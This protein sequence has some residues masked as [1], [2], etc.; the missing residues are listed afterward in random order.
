MKDLKKNLVYGNLTKEAQVFLNKSNVF[1]SF[2]EEFA[3]TPYNDFFNTT[4]EITQIIKV[5]R[6]AERNPKWNDIKKFNELCDGDLTKTLRVSLKKLQIPFDDNYIEYLSQLS[7][8]LGGLIMQLKNHYQRPRPY[9]IAY[10]SN[11]PLHPYETI[12]GNTPAYP[13]GHATQGRFLTKVIASHYPN[14]RIELSKL[15]EQMSN[16]RIVMGLHYPSDNL[17][18]EQIASKLLEQKEIKDAYNF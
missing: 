2:F 10:Y 14:K 1:T 16:S 15:S 4:E 12:S 18:G 13:S 17:F 11:Q 5:Q 3:Y 7:M 6:D 9:Q 8:D